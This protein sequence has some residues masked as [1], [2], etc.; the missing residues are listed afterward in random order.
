M[1]LAAWQ[2]FLATGDRAWL[3]QYG[4]PIIHDTADFWTSRVTYN[5]AKGRYEIHGFVSVDESKIGVT[6]DP[7][8]NAAAKK[9][10]ELAGAAAKILGKSVN[11]K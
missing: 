10:L 7:Y 1:A 9:N 4:Y 5:K 6:N 2:Y 3:E 11:P 8:T